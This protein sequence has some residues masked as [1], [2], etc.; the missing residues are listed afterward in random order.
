MAVMM[1]VTC[2]GAREDSSPTYTTRVTGIVT[3]LPLVES[4][5]INLPGAKTSALTRPYKSCVRAIGN[6]EFSAAGTIITTANAVKGSLRLTT[7]ELSS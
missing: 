3:T 4:S 6:N 2:N 1:F 7:I 5:S